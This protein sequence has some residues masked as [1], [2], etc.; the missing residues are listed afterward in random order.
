MISGRNYKNTMLFIVVTYFLISYP[1]TLFGTTTNSPTNISIRSFDL[2]DTNH[3]DTPPITW[4][5]WLHP[6]AFHDQT[7]PTTTNGLF[8]SSIFYEP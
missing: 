4:Q 1:P 6:V 8:I 3:I 5:R 2:F 7:S